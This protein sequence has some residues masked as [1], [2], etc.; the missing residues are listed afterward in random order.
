MTLI[1]HA[2]VIN[3]E[4]GCVAFSRRRGCPCVHDVDRIL[5]PLVL[6]SAGLIS[7]HSEED[8]FHEAILSRVS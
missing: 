3:D 8:K 1:Q 2:Q 5:H 6:K 4:H 7:F